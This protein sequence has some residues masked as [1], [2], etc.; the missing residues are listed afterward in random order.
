MELCSR[1]DVPVEQT[2]DL[3]LIYADEKLMWEELEKTKADVKQFAETY[4]GNLNTAEN[5]VKCL[6]DM[7]PIRLAMSR[8]W[9]YTGLALEADYTDNALRER[10]EKAGDEMTRM[11]KDMAFVDS[12]ILLAP[13]EELQ[14]ALELTRGCKVYIKDLIAKK[15]H[16]LSPETE[17]TLA[18]LS[19][20]LEVP[21]TVYNTMKLADIAFDS[22]TVDGKEYPLGYSLYEDNYEL[23]ADT[24]VRRAA[25]RQFYDTLKKYQN[26]SWFSLPFS[27]HEWFRVT[28]G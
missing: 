5:I 4:S 9:S 20:S 27:P 28:A 26:T 25:F 14:A 16:M 21:Y 22:F 17:K 7:E 15:Q 24:A 6:D 8:I 11:E 23:E 19:K 12:E 2:W 1:K 3:S 10:E 18:A 13:E